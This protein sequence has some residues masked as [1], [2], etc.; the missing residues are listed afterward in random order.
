MKV[1]AI[2]LESPDE[3]QVFVILADSKAEAVGKAFEQL[4]DRL[5]EAGKDWKKYK[6]CLWT[7]IELPANLNLSSPSLLSVATKPS[8]GGS[9][10]FD[11][12]I[13]KK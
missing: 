5:G 12:Q 13:R 2:E 4:E 3:R 6:V 11:E 8:F 7:Y 1:F 10:G 9:S